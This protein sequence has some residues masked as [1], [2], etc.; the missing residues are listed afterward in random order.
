MNEA[1]VRQWMNRM[2]R[3]EGI[4]PV[5]LIEGENERHVP[6][7]DDDRCR[8]EAAKRLGEK[9]VRAYVVSKGT[10]PATIEHVREG[11]TRIRNE[12]N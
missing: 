4:P 5:V 3:G 7:G 8:I 12:Q 9:G 10:D 1:V 11:I 2:E 6:L